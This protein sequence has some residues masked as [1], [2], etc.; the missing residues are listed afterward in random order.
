MKKILSLLLCAAM[1]ICCASLCVF[2]EEETTAAATTEATTTEATTTETTTTETTT[3]E[4]TTTEEATTEENVSAQQPTHIVFNKEL[5]GKKNIIGSFNHMVKGQISK[6]DEWQGVKLEIAD[7]AD[8]H[9]GLDIAKYTSKFGF[10][11]LTVESTPFIAIR[12][13]TDEIAFDDFELYYWVGD[14]VTFTEECKTASDFIHASK[15]NEI[16]FIFDLTGDAQGQ[17][18]QLRVDIMAAEVGALMYMTDLVFFATEE[19]ALQWCGYYDEQPDETTDGTTEAPTTEVTTEV[20]TEAQ[21]KKPEATTQ[22]EKEEGCGSVIGAGL[23][24]L[25]LIALGAACIKKKD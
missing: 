18:K 20:T 3:T 24:T 13:T 6:S 14:A 7:S 22:A 8:P 17:I 11:N 10:D 1:L 19:E 21:T 12:V 23:I 9:V 5:T 16:Y 25:S 2:A 15:N 4:A